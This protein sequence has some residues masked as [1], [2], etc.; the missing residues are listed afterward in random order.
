MQQLKHGTFRKYICMYCQTKVL[1]QNLIHEHVL[2]H[3]HKYLL[4][5]KTSTKFDCKFFANFS[6]KFR[7]STI[8]LRF[9]FTKCGVWVAVTC[10]VSYSI[11]FCVWKS[12][13]QRFEQTLVWKSATKR[14][15]NELNNPPLSEI[16]L[17]TIVYTYRRRMVV[18]YFWGTG[19][20][21]KS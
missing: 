13:C 1:F 4:K 16:K 5:E 8:P 18:V 3:L 14:R 11:C 6:V 2:T 17:N 15:E 9:L 21:N 10:T 19:A 12:Q 20:T 7:Q